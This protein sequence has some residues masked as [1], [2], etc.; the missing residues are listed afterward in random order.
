MSSYYICKKMT[1]VDFDLLLLE[2]IK[3]KVWHYFGFHDWVRCESTEDM[4]IPEN[5]NIPCKNC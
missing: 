3:S 5:L 1:S 2:G 4:P